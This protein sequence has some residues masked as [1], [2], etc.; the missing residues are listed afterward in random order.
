[1][2]VSVALSSALG[3]TLHEAVDNGD[4]PAVKRALAAAHQDINKPDDD[5]YTPLHLA[6]GHGRLEI[7]EY[8]IATG[9]DYTAVD[10][11]GES[12]LHLAAMA[13]HEKVVAMLLDAGSPAGLQSREGYTPLHM[14]AQHGHATTAELLLV[15]GANAAAASSSGA[16]PLHWAAHHDHAVRPSQ[17]HLPCPG[18]PTCASQ[19][20]RSNGL[21]YICGRTWLLFCYDTARRLPQGMMR[22]R[23]RRRS[24]SSTGT[25]KAH[26][27]R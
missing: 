18:L 7:V 8:L 19:F 27:A 1:M 11:N 16:T 6:S 22:E 14:A 20:V 23:R 26:H 3:A 25:R 4:L 10:E 15:R 21:A 2:L 17:G 5:H 9:A 24:Q 13:G 12:A